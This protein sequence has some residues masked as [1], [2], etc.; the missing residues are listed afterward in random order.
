MSTSW[1]AEPPHDGQNKSLALEEKKTVTETG[2]PCGIMTANGPVRAKKEA[3]IYIDDLDILLPR[4][5]SEVTE[6]TKPG[7]RS[8]MSGARVRRLKW[9]QKHSAWS[10]RHI[11]GLAALFGDDLDDEKNTDEEGRDLKQISPWTIR[12]VIE[13]E[14]PRAHHGRRRRSALETRQPMDAT[15]P[16][17][18]RGREVPEDRQGAGAWKGDV[19][20]DPAFGI[21]CSLAT[22]AAPERP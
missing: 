9:P 21:L 7:G 22:R 17:H 2:D 14:E 1:T 12:R 8:E 16:V 10:L 4:E 19:K 13:L 15:V 6:P 5:W 20:G 11:R 18:A 3:T